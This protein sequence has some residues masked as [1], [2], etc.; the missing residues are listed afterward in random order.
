MHS[1]M[2]AM[3]RT[4]VTDNKTGMLPIYQPHMAASNAAYQHTLALQL[5]QQQQYAPVQREYCHC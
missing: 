5:Q 1:M 4:A 2:P 3:K